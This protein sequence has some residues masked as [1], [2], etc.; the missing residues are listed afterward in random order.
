MGLKL[1]SV[2]HHSQ[3]NYSWW[4]FSPFF[5]GYFTILQHVTKQN[6]HKLALWRWQWR[7]CESEST[8]DTW[9]VVKQ[10]ICSMKNMKELHHVIMSTINRILKECFQHHKVSWLF[11]AFETGGLLRKIIYLSNRSSLA[12]HQLNCK[13]TLSSAPPR[14]STMIECKE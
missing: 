5:N 6:H 12:P 9:H 11:Y 14:A 13:V 1:L 10:M 8:R 2:N 7:Q 4:A 3:M